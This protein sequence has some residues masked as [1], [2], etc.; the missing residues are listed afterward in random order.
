MMRRLGSLSH[1][2][3]GTSDEF[4]ETDSDTGTCVPIHDVVAVL[5]VSAG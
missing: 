4:E 5:L 1:R 2:K 3:T